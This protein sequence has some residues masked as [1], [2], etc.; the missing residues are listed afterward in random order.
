MYYKY[1]SFGF[2]LAS[3]SLSIIEDL[4]SRSLKNKKKTMGPNS[5]KACSGIFQI[6]H[7]IS[8]RGQVCIWAVKKGRKKNINTKY[9]IKNP[10][11]RDSIHEV[12]FALSLALTATSASIAMT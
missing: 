5:Q 10:L 7:T 11:L 4:C 8:S 9:N 12:H 2:L 3:V 6:I 1:I